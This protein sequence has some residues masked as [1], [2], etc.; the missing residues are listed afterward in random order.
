MGPENFV[1][2]VA[3]TIVF[4]IVLGHSPNKRVDIWLV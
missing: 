1:N 2:F 4:G 3:A